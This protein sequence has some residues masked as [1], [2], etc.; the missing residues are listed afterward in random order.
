MVGL[1][2]SMRIALADLN[3]DEL[4]VM[5]PGRETVRADLEGRGRAAGGIGPCG[6]GTRAH[7]AMTKRAP[8]FFV[9]NHSMHASSPPHPD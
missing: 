3:L 6:R 5:Y 1:T 2:P 7:I 9:A 4:R 8:C